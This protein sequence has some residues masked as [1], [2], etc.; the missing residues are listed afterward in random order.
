MALLRKLVNRTRTSQLLDKEEER[1][2]LG[3][4]TRITDTG[5]RLVNADGTFNS[6]RVNVS[7]W[8]W[9]DIFH[10][11]TVMSWPAFFAV[12]FGIYFIVN[13]LFSFVYLGIGIGHL[14]GIEAGSA[15]HNF[16][17]AFFF[18]AQTLTTVGYGRVAPIGHLTSA[19]A[20]FEALIGLLGFAL[21]TGLM[22]G[23]FSRP[24]SM[25]LFSKNA[26]FGPYLDINA[27]M[28]R[29]INESPNE[30]VD[31]RAE[32]SLSRVETLPN[33]QKTRKYYPLKLERS[34][35]NFFPLSWTLVHPITEESPLYGATEQS[36][37]ESDTEFLIYIRAT[38]ETFLQSVHARYSYRYNETVWGAKFRPMFDNTKIEGI[39]KVDVQT[40]HVYDEKPLN[41]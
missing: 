23:R 34:Q 24:K 4:G 27:W 20:A 26:V 21:G 38:E 30:L 22:Y 19:I 40:L 13:C 16:W 8:A 5:G 41:S 18:S 12:T 14:S 39:V 35:V 37:E 36:M 15:T 11:L 33:G 6:R 1:K 7:F 31:V 29:I 25:I 17:E 2:D 28:F 9:A 32:V 3:F 10:R